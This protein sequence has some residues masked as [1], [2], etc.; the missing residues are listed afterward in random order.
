MPMKRKKH[1]GGRPPVY[2]AK[3]SPAIVAQL[4]RDGHTLK[5]VAKIIGVTTKTIWQWS[6][7]H[8]EFCNALEESR[9]KGDGEVAA[10]LFRSA[11][12]YEYD[13]VEQAV[14]GNG[15]KR[16]R[17]VRRHVPPDVTACK[18]W[19]ANRQPDVWRERHQHEVSGPGGGPIGV[20]VEDR[21]ASILADPEAARLAND[22]ARRLA[23]QSGGDGPP[24]N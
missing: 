4:C 24:S 11:C 6:Q 8:P 2:D 23:Y 1:P 3:R 17:R 10:S 15:K 20:K 9:A 19:L 5:E 13:E 7:D 22:L 18:F 14:D 21:L 16:V 12:G